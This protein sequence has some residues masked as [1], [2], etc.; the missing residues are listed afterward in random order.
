MR[1]IDVKRLDRLP[2]DKDLHPLLE[3][4]RVQ[5]HKFVDTLVN[6]HLAGTNRFDKHGEA[7]FGAFRHGRLVAVG[8]VNQ[9]PYLRTR[10]V[11]RVRHVYVLSD[12]RRQ[13]IGKCL[14]LRIIGVA[15]QHFRLLTLRTLN[16]NADKFYRALGFQTEPAVDHAT[17]FLNLSDVSS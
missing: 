11:G 3:N 15:K 12:V 2:A 9:D 6:Q 8:G 13:G 7:L 5:G 16:P 4:S 17:H 1:E 10:D 14:M